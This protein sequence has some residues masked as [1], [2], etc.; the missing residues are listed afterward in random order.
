M[1][2]KL[3]T[4]NKLAIIAH[5]G[6]LGHGPENALSTIKKSLEQ[7][8]EAIEIDIYSVDGEPLITHDR[9][10]G[11]SLNGSGRLQ[12]LSANDAQKLTLPNGE[13]VPT[14]TDVLQQVG[15]QCDINLEIKGCDDIVEKLVEIVMTFV[16]KGHCH[17]EQFIISSFDHRH[18]EKALAIQPDIKRGVLIDGVLTDYCASF[19]HLKGWSIHPRITFVPR[20]LIEDAHQRG[21]KVFVYTVNH[22]KDIEDMITWGVDGIFTDFPE[23]AKKIRDSI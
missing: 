5:R 21:Y 10:L 9:L 20:E 19:D 7:G 13:T 11:K 17:I 2:S 1:T 14:L 3:E 23:R 18:L 8:V 22:E 16:N 15:T 12:D 4:T 6:G